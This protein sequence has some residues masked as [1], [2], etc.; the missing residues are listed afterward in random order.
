M[1]KHFREYQE[2]VESLVPPLRERSQTLL[3]MVGGAVPYLVETAR[4]G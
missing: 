3:D 1:R 4:N 2:A